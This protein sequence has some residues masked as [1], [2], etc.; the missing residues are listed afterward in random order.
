MALDI[1]NPSMCFSTSLKGSWAS[2]IVSETEHKIPIKFVGSEACLVLEHSGEKEWFVGCLPVTKDWTGEDISVY[3]LL[4]F[5]LYADRPCKCH[6]SLSDVDD[7]ES[8]RFIINHDETLGPVNNNIDKVGL[9]QT[10]IPIT[11]FTGDDFD[12]TQTKLVRFL[13]EN[14]NAFYLSKITL[15]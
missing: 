10:E 8:S 11:N 14:N 6:V 7:N 12:I 4:T 15:T 2:N 1:F 5:N 3:N 9:H 13:G